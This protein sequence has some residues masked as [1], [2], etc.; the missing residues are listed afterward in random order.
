MKN[1]EFIFACN[2]IIPMAVFPT[3]VWAKEFSKTE[4]KCSFNTGETYHWEIVPGKHN[5]EYILTGWYTPTG[6]KSITRTYYRNDYGK[7][8]MDDGG[9]PHYTPPRNTHGNYESLRLELKRLGY[10]L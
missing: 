6:N 4:N 1:G 5:E 8:E 3:T 2:T 9:I 7:I 10:A